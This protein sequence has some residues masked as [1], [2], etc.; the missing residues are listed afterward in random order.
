MTNKTPDEL[1]KRI[2]L[3]MQ[4]KDISVV[5]DFLEE[6]TMEILEAQKPQYEKLLIGAA[7]QGIIS[8]RER[9]LALVTSSLPDSDAKKTLIEKIRGEVATNNA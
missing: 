9:C 7:E 6:F 3:A 2:A 1:L 8:E 5:K 4:T